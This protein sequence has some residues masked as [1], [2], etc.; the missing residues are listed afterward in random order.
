M[1]VCC[2]FRCTVGELLMAVTVQTLCQLPFFVQADA[3]A[4]AALRAMGP[5]FLAPDGLFDFG[6]IGL[7]LLV[8]NWLASRGGQPLGWPPVSLTCLSRPEMC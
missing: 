1:A 6:V 7:W 8:I 4:Q 3:S 2:V 5:R